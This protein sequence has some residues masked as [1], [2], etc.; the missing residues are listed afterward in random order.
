MQAFKLVMEVW[1]QRKL[2]R[3]VD[4]KVAES[5]AILYILELIKRDY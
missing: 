3:P 1:Y 2:L 5:T 4:I